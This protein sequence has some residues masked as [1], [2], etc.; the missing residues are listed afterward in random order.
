MFPESTLHSYMVQLLLSSP[1]EQSLEFFAALITATGKELD[2]GEAKVGVVWCGPLGNMALP[3]SPDQSRINQYLSRVND[4]VESGKTSK[5]IRFV[6]QDVV[7]LRG[8]AW[9]PLDSMQK[10]LFRYMNSAGRRVRTP[11]CR[12]SSG[13]VPLRLAQ[14]H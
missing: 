10:R 6:L 14:G 11:M 8:T 2:R 3:P 5:R 7:E 12:W 13:M 1:D 4:I 9:E